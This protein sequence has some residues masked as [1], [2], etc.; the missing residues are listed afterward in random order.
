ML[1]VKRVL[2]LPQKKIRF[3]G[4]HPHH[5]VPAAHQALQDLL[6]FNLCPK[7]LIYKCDTTVKNT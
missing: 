6:C 7:H 3:S 5:E 2:A 4:T 1:T